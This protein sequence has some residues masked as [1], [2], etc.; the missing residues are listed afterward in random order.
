[1]STEKRI[2]GRLILEDGTVFPGFS[3]GATKSSSG[4][5]VFQTG[6]VGYPESLTDPSY[7]GQILVLSY[8]LIGNYGIPSEEKDEYGLPKFFESTQIHV[9]AL[10][11]ADQTDQYSHWNAERSLSSW[12]ADKGIPGLYG[13]DTRALIQRIRESGSCNAKIVI[14]EDDESSITVEDI[15]K[16]HCVA[17]VS[18]KQVLDYGKGDIKV[19]IIDCGMKTN[20]I[21]CFLRRGVAVRVVP[22][23]HDISKET[24]DGLFISNG[25]GNPELCTVTVENIKKALQAEPPKPISASAWETNS[26]REPLVLPPTNSSTATEVTTS[27][28]SIDRPAAAT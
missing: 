23:D 27:L 5:C 6:M 26:W 1:M 2:A 16:V 7:Y 11:V 13:V 22:H 25:P 18:T 21:R 19:L 15:D 10:I 8:P 4:E 20:Q 9:R 28:A 12:L 3:F 14:G 17:R 24:Y